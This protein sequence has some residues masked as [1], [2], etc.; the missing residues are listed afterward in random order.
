MKLA[1]T[2]FGLLMI[3]IGGWAAQEY[4]SNSQSFAASALKEPL[5]LA[6]SYEISNR[7]PIPEFT[8]KDQL[9]QTFSKDKL[10]GKWSLVYV[11]YTSCPD[12]CPTMTGKLAAAYRQLAQEIELQVVFISVDPA[13]DSQ[14]KLK[15]YMDYFEP[16]F[17]AVTADHS[18]LIPITRNL[19]FVYAMVGDGPNYQ[20]DHSA[21]LALLSPEGER[22][23]VIKPKSQKLG[24]VPQISNRALIQDIKLIVNKYS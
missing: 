19:G 5:T 6:T 3:G 13:R 23:A 24:Q 1:I 20:V 4:A 2:T 21:S 15:E 18:Q 8:L 17:L 22:V 11:G 12:I 14:Q 16:E 9:G 7:S 10:K